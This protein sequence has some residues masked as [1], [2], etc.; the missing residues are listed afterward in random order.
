M[1]EPIKQRAI[2]LRLHG[3]SYSEIKKILNISSKGTL[4]YWFRNLSLPPR[5]QNRL[6]HKTA[7]ARKRNLF[8]YNQDRTRKIREQNKIAQKN[9]E[10]EIKTLTP[11]ELLLVGI[12]LYWGEGTKSEKNK[13]ALAVSISNS[14]PKL[15]KAFMRFLREIWGV[16]EEKIKPSIHVH[17]NL[18]I[19]RAK[20]FWARTTGLP[21]EKFHTFNQISAA[22]K[23]KRPKK[24]LPYG[25][26]R[27]RVNSRVLF[28]KMRGYIE[29]L[30]GIT[31]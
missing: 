2:Q 25:T 20:K 31:K 24:F 7:F 9:A 18:D 11:R 19:G 1:S 26:A 4:S 8:K 30:S 14:D 17:P 5:A 16:Q 21:I 15:I 13:N 29:G 10:E 28:Y 23:L 27:I 12:A 22:S 3:K 6:A